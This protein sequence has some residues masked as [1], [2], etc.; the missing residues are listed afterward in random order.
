MT[1]LPGSNHFSAVLVPEA[2]APEARR[3]RIP[4]QAPDFAE[5]YRIHFDFVWR[6]LRRLGVPEPHVDDAAQEVFMVVHRRLGDFEGRSS[7]KSWIFAIVLRVA[8]QA[9]RSAQRLAVRALPSDLAAP[10][11]DDPYEATAQAQARDLVYQL[12]EELDDDKR[13]VF[14]LAELEQLTVPEIA[15]VLSIKLNTA[16]SRLR[17]ARRSF[18]AALA[19]R[20]SPE[21]RR[22]P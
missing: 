16:Y 21:F 15:E 4:P 18:D 2:N 19:A 14:I 7:L 10:E 13:A 22:Q 17:A 5:L 9:R 1:D 11:R 12:L 8:S 6:T 3:R 20:R